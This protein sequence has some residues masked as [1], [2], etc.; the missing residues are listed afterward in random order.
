MASQEYLGASR[1]N[2]TLLAEN[3]RAAEVALAALE[4]QG[5]DTPVGDRQWHEQSEVAAEQQR[6]Q[7]HRERL[8]EAK[9]A[10]VSML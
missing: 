2:D 3:M 5:E 4:R 6:L 1:L 7:R 9:V 10:T 8:R